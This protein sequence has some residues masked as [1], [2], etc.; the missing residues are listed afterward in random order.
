[1]EVVR[2]ISNNSLN[3]NTP[4]TSSLNAYVGAIPAEELELFTK[5]YTQFKEFQ[6]EGPPASKIKRFYEKVRLSV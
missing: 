5:I 1:M 4:S 3:S 2:D 6:L